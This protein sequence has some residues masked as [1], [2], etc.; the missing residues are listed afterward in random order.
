MKTITCLRLSAFSVVVGIIV[1]LLFIIFRFP[2]SLFWCSLPMLF[3]PLIVFGLI[4]VYYNL[5]S[6][7]YLKNMGN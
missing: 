7:Y 2:T 3:Y 4:G 6:Y 5:I 1:F